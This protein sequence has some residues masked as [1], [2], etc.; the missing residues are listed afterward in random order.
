[1]KRA[2]V[3]I[4]PALFLPVHAAISHLVPAARLFATLP[5]MVLAEDEPAIREIEAIP[6]V[7]GIDDAGDWMLSLLTG[8]DHI[9]LVLNQIH[10][11]WMVG[12]VAPGEDY[13]TVYGEPVEGVQAGP[14][15]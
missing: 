8:L 14:A 1:M 11:E 6:G 12:G 7:L 5:L 2:V 9:A 10:P 13:P 4:D 15:I 3:L